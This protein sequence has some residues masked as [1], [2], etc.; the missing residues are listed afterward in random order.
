VNIRFAGR[1]GLEAI[2]D[3]VEKT[4]EKNVKDK[5]ILRKRIVDYAA[6]HGIKPTAAKFAISKNTVRFWLRR[7]KSGIITS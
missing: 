2:K 3:W 7:Y 1:G 4:S 5:K 6:D